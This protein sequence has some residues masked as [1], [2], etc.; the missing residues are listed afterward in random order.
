MASSWLD[1]F[2]A[3]TSYGETPPHVMWWVGVVTI[4]GALQRKVWIE[5]YSFQ[6]T[7]N[8]YLLIVA[9]PNLIHKST[10]IGLGTRLLK[11][12]DGIDFGA[13]STTWQ[14]LITHMAAT[15]QA[16]EINGELF[17]ASCSTIELSE[18]GTF[19]DPSSRELVDALTDLWDG[20][21]GSFKKETKTNGSDEI[22]NPWINIYAGTTPGWINDNFTP[23]LIR[24]GFASRPIYVYCDTIQ[25]AVPYP[26]RNM[27]N[28]EEMFKRENALIY[29]LREISEYA[30]PYRMTEAAFKWGERWYVDFLEQRRR[31]SSSLEADLYTRG[32]THLHKLAMVLSAAKGKFPVIDVEEMEEADFHLNSLAGGIE[33]IFGYVGQSP[34]AKNAKMIVE[35]LAHSGPTSRKD[36]YRRHFFRTISIADFDDA[37]KSAK[38]GGL[39]TEEGSMVDPI[40][41]LT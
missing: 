34:A 36:L 23:R 12:V 9:P 5:Q 40:L 13:Q 17:E 7:P 1:D 37:L 38:A 10:S 22:V 31:A 11:R 2:V 6:W 33:K 16:W 29:R 25:K 18:F 41:T 19:F 30:G 3:H 4:A 20:K 26:S 28:S 32:Q 15:T 27:P 35:A 24:G 39:L 8:F 14:Q 21:L